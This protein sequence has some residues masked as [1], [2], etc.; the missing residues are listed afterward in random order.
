MVYMGNSWD[1]PNNFTEIYLVYN[2][3]II[4]NWGYSGANGIH[5]GLICCGLTKDLRIEI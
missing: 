3:K 1:L 2:G 5:N 4:Y